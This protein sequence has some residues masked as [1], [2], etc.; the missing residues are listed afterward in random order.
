M[1]QD[2]NAA[3]VWLDRI[4]KE[5]KLDVSNMIEQVNAMIEEQDGELGDHDE[6]ETNLK[7]TH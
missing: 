1:R 6:S 3:L 5:A 2:L 7:T 4:H